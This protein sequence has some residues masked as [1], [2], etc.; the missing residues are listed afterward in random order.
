M[1]N[2]SERWKEIDS[3]GRRP[4]RFNRH[5]IL[6]SDDNPLNFAKGELDT[7]QV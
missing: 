3:W 7:Q 4:I 5:H 6:R 2:E 1:S